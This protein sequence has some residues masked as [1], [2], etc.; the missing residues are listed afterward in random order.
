[1]DCERGGAS[2]EISRSLLGMCE[3]PVMR[4]RTPS[5]VRPFDLAPPHVVEAAKRI[6]TNLMRNG[7]GQFRLRARPLGPAPRVELGYAR[8]PEAAQG[9]LME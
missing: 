1:M 8:T 9:E 5:P 3:S 2:S 4:H 6:F 7:V